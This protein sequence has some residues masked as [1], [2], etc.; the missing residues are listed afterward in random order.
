MNDS[1]LFPPPIKALDHDL[2]L[3]LL[4]MILNKAPR[5][6]R[7]GLFLA[8][9]PYEYNVPFLTALRQRDDGRD[10]RL[11]KRLLNYSFIRQLENDHYSMEAVERDFL[12]RCWL[13]EDPQ[14]FRS[15]HERA[16]EFLADYSS[17]DPITHMHNLI[18]HLLISDANR[19]TELFIKT[20]QTYINEHFLAPADRLIQTA[21]DAYPYITSE[22]AT[23]SRASSDTLSGFWSDNDFNYLL[24]FCQARL[25]QLR[26]EWKKS[27]VTLSLLKA[28]KTLPKRLRPY[29]ERAYGLGLAHSGLYVE[30]M[31]RYYNAL[32]L[33][34]EQP[35]SEIEQGHTYIMLGDAYVDLGMAARGYRE[36]LPVTTL[37]ESWQQSVAYLSA[38]SPL[39]MMIYLA[40]HKLYF[41]HPSSWQVLLHQDWIIASLFAWGARS[42]READK[43]L[44]SLEDQ[45][46]EWNRADQKL[47]QLYLRLGDPHQ[48]TQRFQALLKKEQGQYIGTLLKI[49][50]ANGYLQLSYH[51]QA[52][53]QLQV[54]LPLVNNY[55]DPLLKAQ[56]ISLLAE[57]KLKQKHEQAI[58]YF[59]RSLELYIQQEDFVA[60]TEITERLEGLIY[61]STITKSEHDTQMIKDAANQLPFRQYQVRFQHPTL[62]RFRRWSLILVGVLIF[63][64][65]LS[66]IRIDVVN[67]LQLS[68][69]FTIQPPLRGSGVEVIA[70][71]FFQSLAR[72]S[73]EYGVLLWQI[74]LMLLVYAVIYAVMGLILIVRTRLDT[75]QET[76]KSN[77]LRINA[78]QITIGEENNAR[79]I[80]WSDVTHLITVNVA[81]WKEPMPNH[82]A[83]IIATPKQHI[84]FTGAAAWYKQITGRI[85]TYID[86]DVLH[87]NLNSSILRSPLG[88]LYVL[89][90]LLLLTFML[91]SFFSFRELLEYDWFG[92]VYSLIDLYPYFYVG[93][94]IP[95]IWW[96]VGEQLVNRARLKLHL[97]LAWFVFGGGLLS[98][99]LHLSGWF[100]LD[101]WPHIYLS[102]GSLSLFASVLLAFWKAKDSVLPTTFPQTVH[103]LFRH[104]AQPAAPSEIPPLA[105][106]RL[107]LLTLLLLTLIAGLSVDV[108][109]EVIGYHY[110]V[111]GSQKL[112]QIIHVEEEMTSTREAD[113]LSTERNRLLD[114]AIKAYNIS[115]AAV[116]RHVAALGGRAA[117]NTQLE[118]FEE[119]FADYDEGVRQLPSDSTVYSDRA[120]AYAIKSLTLSKEAS[121]LSAEKPIENEAIQQLIEEAEQER[122]RALN[123]INQAIK[124]NQNNAQ[125]YSWR[126][127]LHYSAEQWQDALQ[128]AQQA[129]RLDPSN[130]QAYLN[131]G[132]AIFQLGNEAKKEIIQAT[133][134]RDNALAEEWEQKATTYYQDAIES[135]DEA[136][137]KNN[138]SVDL[139]LAIG[140]AYYQ[141]EAYETAVRRWGDVIEAHPDNW[142]A[143]ILRG[144][145]YWRLA[146]RQGNTCDLASNDPSSHAKKEVIVTKITKAIHD[147]NAAAVLEPKDAFTYRTRAQFHYLL[148]HCPGHDTEE[149]LRFAINDYTR[150]IEY[151]I[152][153]DSYWQGRARIQVALGHTLF[154]ANQEAAA[155]SL[156]EEAT[157]DITEAYA[158]QN[159]PSNQRWLDFI[160]LG[161]QGWYHLR[162]G[163][164][165]AEAGEQA[166]ALADYETAAQQIP[167]TN[168]TTVSDATE[169]AFSA[170][171]MALRLNKIDLAVKWY[172]EGIRRAIGYN[173]PKQARKHLQSAQ[174]KLDRWIA[175]YAQETSAITDIRKALVRALE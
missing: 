100:A 142:L 153:N 137:K 3:H 143:F 30:A 27:N 126:S 25:S 53:E 23:H 109:R 149:Q 7:E 81:W 170:G 144:T 72:P 102:L 164:A 26:G 36:R 41:W 161:A 140:Y 73:L 160:T 148:R 55:E 94:L 63:F 61:D 139:E 158:L 169:A 49:G 17:S 9:I 118:Q 128:D 85:S 51:K 21:T 76:I 83:T 131:Q 58:E 33:F 172:E 173:E 123:D 78:Q 104:D 117:A 92:S 115:L 90:V 133:K 18:Y 121:T 141:L 69:N 42:Y 56:A 127:V 171:M 11:A 108:V 147:F 101:N 106:V 150:A 1:D 96:T 129:I 12:L 70:A 5:L 22:S 122:Q 103:S 135:F 35:N 46:F 163:D 64:M 125:L 91:A 37:V 50:L 4:E 152:E 57:V 107:A 136:Q 40:R 47:A 112:T 15:A 159:S 19:G 174:G 45:H 113:A 2:N 82:S 134:N 39:P 155:L 89:S 13:Q 77:V 167:F 162:R 145:G 154:N 54:I 6:L 157:V 97:P 124:L 84:A 80:K 66:A 110:L 74:V 95:L 38:F 34:S 32:T 87:L 67:F 68:T 175:M 114:E 62:V 138:S 166:A 88:A 24:L 93:L 105:Q 111:V 43:L 8:A 116:P 156:L 65:P 20:F 29:V 120:I 151:D 31:A 165:Y 60:A 119:A 10:E 132:W 52:E 168:S 99:F 44:E 79:T 16:V 75:V 86:D 14:A 130:Q 146:M 59:G 48:A 98:L 28:K 71:P